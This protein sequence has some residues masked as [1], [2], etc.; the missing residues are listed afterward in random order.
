MRPNSIPQHST[1]MQI[2]QYYAIHLEFVTFIDR[3]TFGHTFL[4]RFNV[5]VRYVQVVHSLAC[6][7]GLS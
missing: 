7:H 6:H 2:V 5:R 3:T 1:A 4:R